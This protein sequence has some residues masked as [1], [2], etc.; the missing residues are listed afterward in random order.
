MRCARRSVGSA[1]SNLAVMVSSST[2]AIPLRLAPYVLDPDEKGHARILVVLEVDTSRLTLHGEGTRRT[3][4]LDLSVI[5]MTRDAGTVF[6]LD[7]RV[8]IDLDAGA[9]GGW[10]SLTREIRLPPG[11]GQ[12]RVLARDVASGLAGL[13]THR[14]TVPPLNEPYL[15]TPM[16]TDRMIVGGGKGLRLVPVAHRTFQSKGL[17]YCSYEVVGMTN[18]Q[19][20]A[21]MRVAGGYTLSHADGRVVSQSSPARIA[22]A[23]GGKVM[24]LFTLPLRDLEPGEYELVLDVVDDSSGRSLQSHERFVLR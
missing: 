22:V 4:A 16:L 19:G 20:E 5:G 9:A 1:A 17:L 13:V 24:R 21:T 2:D 11:V 3:G 10:M 6:P 18:G 12:V 23:L 15:T 14:F 7:E 8:L